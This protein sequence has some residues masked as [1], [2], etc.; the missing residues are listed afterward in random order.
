[1]AI[2]VVKGDLENLNLTFEIN[3]KGDSVCLFSMTDALA[4]IP[5]SKAIEELKAL[6]EI[7]EN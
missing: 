7:L 3:E 4:E 2:K 1:M 6:L 5:I